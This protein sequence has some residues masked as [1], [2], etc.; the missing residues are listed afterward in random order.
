MDEEAKIRMSSGGEKFI[1][2]FRPSAI[3]LFL[4]GCFPFSGIFGSEL[5]FQ[6]VSF[7]AFYSI[8]FLIYVAAVL[9]HSLQMVLGSIPYSYVAVIIALQ[10]ATFVLNAGIVII[11]FLIRGTRIATLFS[12]A[13]SIPHYPQKRLAEIAI[14]LGIYILVASLDS[15]AMAFVEFYV[16]IPV[17]FCKS[18]VIVVFVGLLL[19]VTSFVRDIMEDLS[20]PQ[21]ELK[22]A[23]HGMR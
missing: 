23:A 10:T 20:M 11:F 13:N 14:P 4:T 12:E 7:P 8:G 3:V 18:G 16:V 5:Q 15:V 19:R 22:P 2:S 21:E 9:V 6:L 17:S 1:A